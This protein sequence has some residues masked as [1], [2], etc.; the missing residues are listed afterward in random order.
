[1][2]FKRVVPDSALPTTLTSALVVLLTIVLSYSRGESS[3][4]LTD[5]VFHLP[6]AIVQTLVAWHAYRQSRSSVNPLLP[7]LPWSPIALELLRAV[8]LAETRSIVASFYQP[9]WVGIDL[10][11][12]WLLL[13]AIRSS[14]SSTEFQPTAETASTAE[15]ATSPV[16]PTQGPERDT[17]AIAKDSPGPDAAIHSYVTAAI[18]TRSRETADSARL[19]MLIMILLVLVGGGASVGLW[20]VSQL[21]R[22]RSLELERNKLVHLTSSL[23]QLSRQ[24]TPQQAAA[25]KQVQAFIQDNYNAAHSY[26][27]LLRDIADKTQTSWP[28]IA[29][30]ATVAILT[31]F[32]VQIFFSVYKY[33]QH[34]S[35]LLARKA[36]ALELLGVF[37]EDRQGVR[38]EM[39]A[40]AKEGFP[41]F[42]AGPNTPLQDVIDIL[43]KLRKARAE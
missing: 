31:L 14:G 21:D 9:S 36:E 27:V 39:I 38:K 10:C 43:D 23:E 35:N 19:S 28:D 1:M 13:C 18:R 3:Y 7:L 12:L 33:S 17:V 25:L 34:L 5:E 6:I 16:G 32:L 40:V 37:A 11:F 29:I 8:Y 22:I 30:R 41:G 26:E 4:R 42:S 24:N 20:F 2:N 15:L